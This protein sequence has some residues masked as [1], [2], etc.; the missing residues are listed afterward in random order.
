MAKGRNLPHAGYAL[1]RSRDCLHWRVTGEALRR[2]PGYPV[3]AMAVTTA[4]TAIRA[5]SMYSR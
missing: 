5:M 1:L 2:P 4:M 3:Q